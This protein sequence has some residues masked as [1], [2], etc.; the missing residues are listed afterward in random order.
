MALKYLLAGQLRYMKENGFEVIM[1]SADG[2]EREEVIKN[3]G[4]EHHII[5]MTRRIT[6]FAD[7]R[8]LWK[9]YRYFKKQKP[10]IVHSHT[11][12]AGML[13]ML[14]AKMAGIKIR[15]HTIAGLRFMTASGMSRKILVKAEK[16]TGRWATHAWPNSNSL[17]EYI[18]ENKLVNPAKLQVIGYGSSNGINLQRFSVASLKKEKIEEVKKQLQYDEQLVYL[19][20][21]GRIVKDKGMDELLQAFQQLYKERNELRLVLLGS[22]EDEFDPVSDEARTVLKNHPGIIH[23]AWS[24]QVEYFMHLAALLL[25][26]SYRE[27]FPNVLLQAG[28]MGCPILCSRI[29]GNIDIVDDGRTGMIFEVKNVTSLEAKLRFALK[30]PELLRTYAANLRQKIAQQFDQRFV[31]ESLKNKYLELIN[32]QSSRR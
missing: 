25:H 18:K 6:P 13:A 15:I 30:E 4:C 19:L 17:L 14:A 27:G 23:I 2:K 32:E 12:K 11:P 24:D 10:D 26:P 22:F 8:S 21:V 31:H 20:S 5:F 1:V 7:L 28:A 16:L 3:E 29:E 9:L